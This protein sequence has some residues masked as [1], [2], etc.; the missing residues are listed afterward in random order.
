MW[1][2]RAVLHFLV[3]EAD[4][5]AYLATLQAVVRP[6]GCVIIAAFAPEGA[7]MCSGLPG[8]RYDEQGL[9]ELLGPEF[10]LLEHSRYLYQ[11]P[12]DEPRP[13]VYT[14]FRRDRAKD[15]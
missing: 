9:A 4:R 14:L 8:R 6:G 3:D 5:Q 1:H 10:T 12:T 2:D 15:G 11:T 7:T 13:Y